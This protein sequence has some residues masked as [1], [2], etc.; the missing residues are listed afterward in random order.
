MRTVNDQQRGHAY[1]FSHIN[2]YWIVQNEQQR[3]RTEQKG[4]HF[5]KSHMKRAQHQSNFTAE[6]QIL[7]DNSSLN[8]P[9]E[10]R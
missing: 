6:W 8:H 10:R 9:F 5:T 2:Y 4:T 3:N 1:H 7:L